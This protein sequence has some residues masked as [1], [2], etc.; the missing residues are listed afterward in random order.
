MDFKQLQSYVAVVKY[1]SFTTA[2][3]HLFLSQP[4]ISTHIRQ[5]EEELHSRLLVRTTKSIEVTPRGKEL[6][7]NA[8]TILGIWDNM[9]CRFTQDEN[10]ILQL[11]ASTLPATYLLPELLPAFDKINPDVYFVLHQ[12][13]NEQIISGLLNGSYDIGMTGAP[14]EHEN[15]TCETI[16]E[17]QMVFITPVTPKYLTLQRDPSFDTLQLLKEPLIYRELH[18]EKQKN[19]SLLLE[20]LQIREEQLNIIARVN[21]QETV[22]HLVAGGLGVSLIS[23]KAAFD[24]CKEKRLLMFPL[25]EVSISRNICILY[26]KNYILSDQVKQFIH[27]VKNFYRT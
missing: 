1:G 20:K 2:S 10:P 16:Y 18:N 8:C 27:F 6:Y 19:V 5:L 15:L 23:Q 13:K 3:K 9:V 21:D 22:K 14:I 7:D 12:E 4:T 11:A 25:S 17:D 24:L 26:H